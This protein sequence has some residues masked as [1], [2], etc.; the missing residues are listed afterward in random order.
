MKIAEQ[1]KTV[2]EIKDSVIANAKE[3]AEDDINIKK[4]WERMGQSYLKIMIR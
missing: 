3:M 4:K 1:G 2:S